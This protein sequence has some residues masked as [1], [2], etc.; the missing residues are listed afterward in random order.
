MGILLTA[1]T[2]F[3]ERSAHRFWNRTEARP[4]VS[5]RLRL[6]TMMILVAI[7]AF[8]MAGETMRRRRAYCLRRALEHRH[9][10]LTWNGKHIPNALTRPADEERIASTNPHAA[11]HL[12]LVASYRRVASRP[13]EALPV[14]APEPRYFFVP[15]D[16]ERPVSP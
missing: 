12:R 15:P 3:F 11:W 10:L 13:W 9:I 5:L 1:E 6:R 7:V 16:Q 14:E 2:S 8:A 4:V